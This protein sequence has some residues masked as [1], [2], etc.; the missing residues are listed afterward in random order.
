MADEVDE[1]EL[2]ALERALTGAREVEDMDMDIDIDTDAL[3]ALERNLALDTGQVNE[4]DD[5]IMDNED[6][7][8]E[9][10]ERDLAPTAEVHEP[11]KGEIK[12]EP[13]ISTED[14]TFVPNLC[15]NISDCDHCESTKRKINRQSNADMSAK[16]LKLDL[17][18]LVR[19]YM[20]CLS[21]DT[22]M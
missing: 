11:R 7:L 2:A 9:A 4:E 15:A 6:E 17:K 5:S 16:A 13:P 3:E 21:F 1:N 14:F 18:A 10:V 22:K 20:F 8:W 19:N 12:A